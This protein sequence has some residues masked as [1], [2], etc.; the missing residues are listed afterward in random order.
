MKTV[1]I[2]WTGI[3]PL[4][5]HNGLLA[6]QT[7]PYTV[8]IRKIVKKGTKKLTESDYERRDRLEWEGSLY[9]TDGIGPV[10]ISDAIE[11]VIQLGAQK[12]RVGKDV[13]A[14]VFCDEPEYKLEYKG[15]RTKD[16]LY[17][18]T[19]ILRKAVVVNKAR[20][21]RVRPRFAEG[22]NVTFTLEYDDTIINQKDILKASSDAGALIGLYDWHPKYGRFESQMI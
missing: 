10:V 11:R 14:A 12:S 3:R 17:E 15:P 7:N 18:P 9:W 2:K 21:I 6:D 8:E 4:V 5:M 13:Q 1:T 19:F 20:I 22:W 16:E